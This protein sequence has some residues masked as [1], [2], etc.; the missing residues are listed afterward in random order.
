MSFEKR[1]PYLLLG[2]KLWSKILTG[3]SGYDK[4]ALKDIFVD[5]IQA[6]I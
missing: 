5:G 4:K 6:S 1:K 2:Q 3:G